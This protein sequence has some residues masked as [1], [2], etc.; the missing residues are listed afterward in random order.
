M[1]MMAEILMMA[2]FDQ[3]ACDA[4]NAAWQF[5]HTEP[6][7]LYSENIIYRNKASIAFYRSER[8]HIPKCLLRH[9]RENYR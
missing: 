7:I 9:D 2:E 1:F 8:S 6:M 3:T 4:P 5:R